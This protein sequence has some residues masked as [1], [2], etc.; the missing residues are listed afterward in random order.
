MNFD[1]RLEMLLD[2][3][4]DKCWDIVVFTETWREDAEEVFMT[5]GGHTWFGSGGCKGAY[6]IVFLLHAQWS[7]SAFMAVSDRTAAL[8]VRMHGHDMTFVGVY[9]PHSAKD[10]LLVESVYSAVEDQLQKATR[11]CRKIV[12]AG[13]FN[14]QVGSAAEGDDGGVVGAKG[15]GRRN[16][17][18][19]WLIQWCTAHKLMLGN[20]FGDGE[21]GD[22]WT[23]K[24]GSRLKQLD[25]L[26]FD[27]WM[28]Q[29][30]VTC[31]ASDHIDTGSDHRPVVAELRFSDLRSKGR[32]DGT[33]R[34]SEAVD[35]NVY[36]HHVNRSLNDYPA[37]T[38]SV[39]AKTEFLESAMGS[40][41]RSSLPRSKTVK[42]GSRY[43]AEIQSLIAERRQLHVQDRDAR[44]KRDQ[45]TAL[46][47][48]IRALV[49]MKVRERRESRIQSILS[50]FRS[51]KDI[52][53]ACSAKKRGFIAS[54][55]DEGGT[56]HYSKE[57]VAEVFARFY[58]KL[59]SSSGFCASTGIVS[60]KPIREF[61]M[62]ELKEALA[63]MKARK[64]NDQ[65]GIVAEMVKN[66]GDTL[67]Q[68]ILDLFNHITSP[69]ALPPQSWRNTKLVVLFKK[70]D[71]KLVSNYRPIAI[72]PI[73]YK[74]FSRMLCG[75]IQDTVMSNQSIDQAAYRKGFSA[76]DHLLA[77]TL[78]VE[79]CD[80]WGEELWMGLVD[81][82]KAF[83]TVLHPRLWTVLEEL[84]VE[85]EYILLLKR[86]YACQSATVV[87]GQESRSFSILRGVKQGDPISGLLFISVMEIIF[88]SL[89]AKWNKLNSRRSGRYIGLVIDDPEDPLT[90]LRFA[91]DV[92]LFSTSRQ[93]IAKMLGHLREEALKY[94]LVVHLG[95]TT[96]LTTSLVSP[97]DTVA[98]G[99]SLVG[100]QGALACE[101]YLGRKVCLGKYHETELSNRIAA[102]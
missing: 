18:G 40:A 84:S 54:V 86:L 61:R 25:Y 75:R 49:Q 16:A 13:D 57:S 35:S 24:N 87:A 81:F 26:I 90:N 73:L 47:K 101:K 31:G 56:E 89:K 80:E 20:T 74:L 52:S 70:G 63:K 46:S 14:A 93:D 43:D 76:E 36:A 91:D 5:E 39:A 59:Y 17:R 79:R 33:I 51:L 44:E 58:E 50:E 27:P 53:K 65:A 85:T 21:A 2:E 68:C 4:R 102:G 94:G 83:D 66:G 15:F 88:R 48:R 42:A 82:E 29:R 9:M 99:G 77:L 23:Y 30:L 37:M 1:I 12:L 45:K 11:S 41:L 34:W 22:Q 6:G 3:L 97:G 100:I 32:R 28:F 92:A 19:D 96:V 98:I 64:S 8:D 71:P 95:K 60:N 55:K 72:L 67:H 78:V 69:D 62:D 10:D 7:Y 38:G